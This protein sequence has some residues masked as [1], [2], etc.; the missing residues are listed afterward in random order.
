M[1]PYAAPPGRE[2]F[3]GPPV[4]GS[5]PLP[6]HTDMPRPVWLRT[7]SFLSPRETVTHSVSA[8]VVQV[9]LVTSFL[10]AL[11]PLPA[12]TVTLLSKVTVRPDRVTVRLSALPAVA[13]NSTFVELTTV[14]LTTVAAIAG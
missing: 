11:Q 5:G 4:M 8:D 10:T 12:L 7:G 2:S 13:L 14:A 6:P 1:R 9:T 3:F